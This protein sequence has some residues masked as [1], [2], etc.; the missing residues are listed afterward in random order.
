[1]AH[2]WRGVI[3]EYASGSPS[4]RRRRSSAWGGRHAAVHSAWLSG[5]V[6]GDVWLKVRATIPQARSRIAA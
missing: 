6:R 3:E 2:L 4:P 5:I 1:M